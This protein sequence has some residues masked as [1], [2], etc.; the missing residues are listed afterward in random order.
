M[1]VCV[2]V[3]VGGRVFVGVGELTGVVPGTV[4]VGVAV[5]VGVEVGVE[6]GVRVLVAVGVILG[7]ASGAMYRI[8]S[9]GRLAESA[10]SAEANG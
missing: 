5:L 9:T 2:A 3:G 6:V 7:G 4:A 1:T 10:C 8:S